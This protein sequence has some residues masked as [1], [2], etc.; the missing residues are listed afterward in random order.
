MP[1]LLFTE[2]VKDFLV[3]ASVVNIYKKIL[4]SL[5]IFCVFVNLTNLKNYA[6]Y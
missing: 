4:T 5:E 1:N 2:A 3:T 6:I